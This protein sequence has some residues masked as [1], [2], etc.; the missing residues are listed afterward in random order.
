MSKKIKKV[1][2]II[3]II[4]L[5]LVFYQLFHIQA[6]K[7][8]IN[9]E[10]HDI[11]SARVM[12]F[13]YEGK[14]GIASQGGFYRGNTDAL[15]NLFNN[16]KY[17]GIKYNYDFIDEVYSGKDVYEITLYVDDLGLLYMY[18]DKDTASGGI[19]TNNNQSTLYK[20]KFEKSSI[21][22]LENYIKINDE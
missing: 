19:A 22:F 21:S 17:Q 8:Q 5:I 20:I 1:F 12:L 3:A 11:K 2:F 4:I 15:A 16:C 10:N 6:F 18:L 13:S 9:F 14:E 7:N